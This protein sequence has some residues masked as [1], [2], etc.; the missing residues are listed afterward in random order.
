MNFILKKTYGKNQ[1]TQ[2]HK[3]SVNEAWKE[4]KSNIINSIAKAIGVRRI[5]MIGK[6]NERPWFT[7]KAK[8][9]ALKKKEVY[10][11]YK[12][13]PTQK[14][15]TRYKIIRNRASNTIKE[16]KKQI[17]KLF[18]AKWNTIYKSKSQKKVWNVLRN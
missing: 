14:E 18:L 3:N 1:L 16:L 5:N 17:R 12:N 4:I 2:Y 7:D 8:A 15:Y 6:K 11:N 9:L 13:N 10:I